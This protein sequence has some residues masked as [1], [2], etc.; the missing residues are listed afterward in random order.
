M[1]KAVVLKAVNTPLVVSDVPIPKPAYGEILV[2]VRAAALNPY[3]FHLQSGAGFPLSYPAVLGVDAAGDVEELGETVQGFA[4][5]DPVFFPGEL[6]KGHEAFQQ[7]AVVPVWTV[8]KIPSH[9]SYAEASS[10][11]LA[12]TTAAFPLLAK[13]AI[14]AGLNPSLD[15]KV[16]FSGQ[17]ALVIGGGSSVGQFA[18]QILKI[19]GFS[20]IIAYASGKHTDYL[21]SLG[22]T[23]IVDR[24]NV[25]FGALS[26]YLKGIT[27]TPIKT[28]YVAYVSSPEV[29]AAAFACLAPNGV[30]GTAVP[31]F[32]KY[33]DDKP[34]GK[35]V[36]GSAASVHIPQHR[37]FGALM[38]KILPQWVQDGVIKPNR[39]EILPGGLN[40]VPGGVK[41][42]QNGDVSGVKL[43][44]NPQ[45]TE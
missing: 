11:P 30:M 20:T 45:E 19:L 23:H 3:E 43:V 17:A 28:I 35:R 14:G 5:G 15:P 25:S 8:G 44:V 13:N 42:L 26:D 31:P 9:L 29:Q 12:F 34:T 37:E 2:K 4:K 21:I 10:I 18:I 16:K 39:V 32:F 41:R 38:W 1:Q 24:A 27:S 6:M 22:A 33:P 7:Y 36:F 40:A